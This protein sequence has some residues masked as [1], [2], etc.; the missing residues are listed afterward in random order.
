ME[1]RLLRTA[2]RAVNGLAMGDN[3]VGQIRVIGVSHR[4]LGYMVASP[5]ISCL[6]CSVSLLHT[7]CG[8]DTLWK[9]AILHPVG[10]A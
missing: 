5:C 1:G 9:I 10:D 2:R 3:T 8:I 7:V 4:A 6:G